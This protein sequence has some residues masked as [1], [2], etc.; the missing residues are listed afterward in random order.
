MLQLTPDA[1]TH[2]RRVRRQRGLDDKSAA[3]FV[4]RGSGVGLTFAST[5]EP[6]DRVIEREDISVFVAPALADA[7]ETSVIDAQVE[8]GK[9][10]LVLRRR[11]AGKVAARRAD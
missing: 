9:S 3:R 11:T 2:L 6:G 4:P 1:T 8:D 5:P 7:L 10:V